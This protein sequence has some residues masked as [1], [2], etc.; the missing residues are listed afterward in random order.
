[1]KSC[2]CEHSVTR[3]RIANAKS[4]VQKET[5]VTA[6]FSSKQLL[7][8]AFAQHDCIAIECK[9]EQTWLNTK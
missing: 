7:L 4:A 8:F 5:A 2:R 1:M 6:Y 3:E 9:R